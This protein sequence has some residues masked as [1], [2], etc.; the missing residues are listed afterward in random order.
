MRAAEVLA[1]ETLEIV[2]DLN[3][4]CEGHEGTLNDPPGLKDA[5]ITLLK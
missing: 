2:L 4:F 3:K 1:A 5:V